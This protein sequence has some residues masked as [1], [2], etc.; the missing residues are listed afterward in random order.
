[1]DRIENWITGEKAS[2]YL[3]EKADLIILQRNIF[4]PALGAAFHWRSKGKTICVD[5]DD[6]YKF[7]TSDIDQRRY[8]FYINGVDLRE[9][10]KVNLD[11]KPLDCMDWGVKLCGSVSSPSKLICQDWQYYVPTYHLPNYLETNLYKAKPAYKEP[12]KIY[13]GWGGGGSH[14]KSFRDSGIKKALWNISQK[15]KNTVLLLIGDMNLK[16]VVD[17]PQG[18]LLMS[19]SQPQLTFAEQMTR[20]DIGL[21]PLAGEYD[22]RRSW[23][24]SAEYSLMGIPWVGSDYEPNRELT[25]SCGLLTENSEGA[26]FDCLDRMINRLQDYQEQARQTVT[27]FTRRIDIDANVD[28][29]IKTYEQIVEKDKE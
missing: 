5:F 24:K 16:S 2:N 22:R 12:G 19:N 6:G 11:P 26:W 8:D 7:I 4:Y 25:S 15:Y 3:A 13:I 10:K 17:W 27:Y 21:I 23:L 28:E 20:F 1:V 14:L 29:L 18:R 9:G